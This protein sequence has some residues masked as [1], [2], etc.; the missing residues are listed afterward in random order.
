MKAWNASKKCWMKHLFL[1]SSV[2]NREDLAHVQIE[3][4]KL[5]FNPSVGHNL[6]L[7]F[8]LI[9]NNKQDTK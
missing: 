7:G 2:Q 4:N 6:V 1:R 9:R 3:A 8:Q 5:L